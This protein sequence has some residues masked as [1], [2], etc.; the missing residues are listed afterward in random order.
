MGGTVV[1]S[2]N[3]FLKKK[4]LWNFVVIFLPISYKL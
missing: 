4:R 2:V 1:F 3:G